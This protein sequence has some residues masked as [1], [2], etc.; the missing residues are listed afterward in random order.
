MGH[1][2]SQK[3]YGPDPSNI[4]AINNMKAPQNVKEVQRFLRMCSFYR[5]YVLRYVSIAVPLTELTKRDPPFVWT[6]ECQAAFEA[7]KTRM[8]K[9][10]ILVKADH[11]KRFILET[12]ASQNHVGAVL[13]Q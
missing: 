6:P 13:M 10:P 11:G 4:E 9:A 1:I 12:D 7:S 5:R 3:G 2:V 8:T